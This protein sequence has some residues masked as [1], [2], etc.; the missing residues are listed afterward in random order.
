M[1]LANEKNG[2]DL[3]IRNLIKDKPKSQ[4]FVRTGVFESFC[5]EN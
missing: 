2:Y 3:N 1:P 5:E 4:R